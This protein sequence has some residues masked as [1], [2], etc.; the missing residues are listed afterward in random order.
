MLW[1]SYCT[2]MNIQIKY[3]SYFEPAGWIDL[4]FIFTGRFGRRQIQDFV[5][6]GRGSPVQVR[7]LQGLFH[8]SHH[9]KMPALLLREVCAP[10]L[11]EE[12]AVLRLRRA[13]QRGLQSGKRNY[14]QNGENETGFKNWSWR[15]WEWRRWLNKDVEQE[16]IFKN[17]KWS[18]TIECDLVLLYLRIIVILC[19]YETIISK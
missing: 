1:F 2:Q 17:N 4:Q 14:C 7:P 15:Q 12:S 16:T 8:Q 9:D 6:W 3:A 13:D 5:R 10:T 11:Q 18:T 19:F